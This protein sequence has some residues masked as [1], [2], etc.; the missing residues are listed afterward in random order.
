MKKVEDKNPGWSFTEK[1]S[2]RAS[3]TVLQQAAQSN[4]S[5]DAYKN[6]YSSQVKSSKA[7]SDTAK[8]KSVNDKGWTMMKKVSTSKNID[9]PEDIKAAF[10]D[11][12]GNE[13]A[14][15]G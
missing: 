8:D 9:T 4:L 12:E 5:I 2:S 11:N 3:K 7:V 15:Q 13:V 6:K 1:V 10:F 14:A